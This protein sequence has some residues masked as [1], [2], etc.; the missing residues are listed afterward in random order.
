MKFSIICLTYK[1][2][3]FL[4]ESIYSVINQTYLDWELL[5]I[6][7]NPL[8]TLHY[9]HPKI[10][11]FNLDR[12]FET[13]GE[14][15]NFGLSNINGDLILQLDD[16]DFLMPEYLNN[17]KMAIGNHTW[18]MTQ[19][20]I[21]YYEHTNKM[22]LSPT[23]QYNTFLYHRNVIDE[24]FKYE[25]LNYDELSPFYHAVIR[26]SKLS[27]IYR[28]LKSHEYGYV[29]RQD[30]TENRKYIMSGFKTETIKEQNNILVNLETPVGDII[31]N[32]KWS[33]DY[34]SIIKNN[35]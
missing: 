22:I 31:L 25:L 23:P 16:D 15:R 3:N 11:I 5:I 9:T 1:R 4:E 20:P 12:K 24:G 8:Q 26:R 32:P 35:L 18:M 34:I 33:K 28:Q 14:K 30:M 27:G 7:D 6:N 19:R 29:Y 21:L 13:L 17:L 2:L 10:R